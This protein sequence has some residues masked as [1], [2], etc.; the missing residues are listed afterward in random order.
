MSDACHSNPLHVPDPPPPYLPGLSMHSM[1]LPGK[2][3]SAGMSVHPAVSPQGA[4]EMAFSSGG[5]GEGMGWRCREPSGCWAGRRA[6]LRVRGSLYNLVMKELL[7]VEPP[8]APARASLQ[9]ARHARQGLRG[10]NILSKTLF[11]I[12]PLTLAQIRLRAAQI[13]SGKPLKRF[14]M[15]FSQFEGFCLAN[16]VQGRLQ[17]SRPLLCC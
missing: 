11:L 3:S 15:S 13:S 7:R 16:P 10:D 1:L 9:R 4:G 14:K 17:A 8:P 12:L 2:A 5:G 6:P